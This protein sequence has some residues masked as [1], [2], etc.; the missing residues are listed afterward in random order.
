V[1]LSV[2]RD[3]FG[4]AAESGFPTGAAFALV[5]MVQADEPSA[6]TFYRAS[7]AS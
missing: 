5:G 7:S 1:P 4:E 6:L 3:Y 2:F